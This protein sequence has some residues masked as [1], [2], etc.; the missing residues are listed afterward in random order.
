MAV[1]YIVQ[2]TSRLQNFG[3]NEH[4]AIMTRFLCIKMIDS[5][6]K[7]FGL[8]WTV[9]F[10]SLAHCK[11]H[12][13]QLF[14]K[15]NVTLIDIKMIIS[16]FMYIKGQ[17]L[18]RYLNPITLSNLILNCAI[19]TYSIFASI[20]GTFSQLHFLKLSLLICS[21]LRRHTIE[22]RNSINWIINQALTIP[23]SQ[24]KQCHVC[25]VQWYKHHLPMIFLGNFMEW[26]FLLY[27]CNSVTKWKSAKFKHSQ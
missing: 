16:N 3:C 4:S 22:Y 13:A 11:L 18:I 5:N 25:G 14:R 2:S 23:Y 19:W 17:L 15:F 12:L 9:S 20:K 10:A 26:N 21:T 8:Q 27:K 7:T 24:V 1:K 6:V